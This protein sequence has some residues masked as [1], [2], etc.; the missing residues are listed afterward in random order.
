MWLNAVARCLDT[1]D[2]S[3]GEDDGLEGGARDVSVVECYVDSIVSDLSRQVS[4]RAGA[5]SIVSA[6][7]RSFTRPFDRDSETA[8]ACTSRVYDE[9]CGSPDD[10]SDEAGSGRVDSVGVA[11]V[12]T[13]DSVRYW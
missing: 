6:V 12:H 13:G 4:D 3:L 5:V 2:V 10:S 11:S 7:D 9:V 1:R 8:L